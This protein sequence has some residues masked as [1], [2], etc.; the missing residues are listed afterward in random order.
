MH[1][2]FSFSKLSEG[3]IGDSKHSSIA[4]RMHLQNACT[5]YI[6][7]GEQFFAHSF[8]ILGARLWLRGYNN[9]FLFEEEQCSFSSVPWKD[10]AS[11]PG[12]EFMIVSDV[13]KGRVNRE[14]GGGSGGG[15]Y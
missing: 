10:E 1:D 5:T 7:V 4:L 6:Y 9:S 12:Y 14:A 13:W 8:A 11:S 3:L 2:T 15:L